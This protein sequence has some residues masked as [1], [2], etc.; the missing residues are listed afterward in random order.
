VVRAEDSQEPGRCDR[1]DG[2]MAGRGLPGISEEVIRT[3]PFRL[4]PEYWLGN[5]MLMQIQLDT[6]ADASHRHDLDFQ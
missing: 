6:P 2:E 4:F 3:S 5:A 1:C